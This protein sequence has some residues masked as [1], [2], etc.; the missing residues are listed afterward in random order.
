[1]T[2]EVLNKNPQARISDELEQ[3]IE[4]VIRAHGEP[5]F[6]QEY[7]LGVPANENAG[8]VSHKPSNKF[9]MSGPDFSA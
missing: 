3:A 1:M 6:E 2:F 9:S 4:A 7:R 8:A 5:A